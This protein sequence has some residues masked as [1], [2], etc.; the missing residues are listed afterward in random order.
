MK[1]YRLGTDYKKGKMR[2][3]EKKFKTSIFGI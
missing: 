1:T 2:E 3:Q